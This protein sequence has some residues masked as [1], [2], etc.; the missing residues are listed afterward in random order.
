MAQTMLLVSFLLG[1]GLVVGLVV[2]LTRGR[3]HHSADL[4]GSGNLAQRLGRATRKPAVWAA[5]FVLL[6]LLAGG[7]TV[8]AVGGY[9]VSTD[10]SAGATTLLATLGT[11]LVVGYVFY[12]TFV[13][14]RARGLHA[15]QAAA[16]GSWALGLLVLVAVAASLLGFA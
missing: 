12:G 6:T 8:L 3:Y 14:A 10:V 5:T 11:V 13:A 16:F 15:A 2:L 1:I 9:G 4:A 7:A